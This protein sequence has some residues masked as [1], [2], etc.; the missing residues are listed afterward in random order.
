M[1]EPEGWSKAARSAAAQKGS[2]GG[3]A[4]CGRA[5][6]RWESGAPSAS[7]AELELASG[8]EAACRAAV[9]LSAVG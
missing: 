8:V 9:I 3:G 2:A 1:E 4:A 7:G 5:S 6:L